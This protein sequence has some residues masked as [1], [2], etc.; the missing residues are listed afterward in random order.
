MST[1]GA[2]HRHAFPTTTHEIQ[3]KVGMGRD[4]LTADLFD[5]PV[6]PPPIGG[7][8][9]YSVELRHVLSAM[10]DDAVKR[11]V[12]RNRYE[13]A[14]RMS[15]LIGHEISK[16]MLDAWTAESKSLWRFPFEYAGAF[17]AA[18]ES[19]GLQEL[20][21]RK[22]GTRV[23]VG[24]ET[25]LAELGRIHKQRD[26]LVRRERAIKQRIGGRR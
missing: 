17:E 1:D 2:P 8:L 3:G 7:S 23:L 12:I 24:E 16:A 20:L 10:I 19:M 25:L 5:V 9:D 4:R 15:E 26:E 22:R 11:G 13:L 21:G 6:A 18:C 14:A